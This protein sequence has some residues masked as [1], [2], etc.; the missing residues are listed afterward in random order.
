MAFMATLSFFSRPVVWAQ[1]NYGT[2]RGNVID[3]TGAV[4]P[5]VEVEATR[6]S[7]NVKYTA[8]ST[9]A[10]VYTIIDLPLGEYQ[11]RA[12]RTGFKEFV[13]EHVFVAVASTTT[14]NISLELGEVTQRVT[15]EG[16]V[17]PLLTPD[18][19]NVGTVVEK[20]L[21]MDLPLSVNGGFRDPESFLVLT[22]GIT[23]DGFSKN[24]N[25]STWMASQIVVEGLPVALPDVPGISHGSA[26]GIGPGTPPIE[27]YQEFKVSTTLMPAEQGRGFGLSS[28]T[29]KSGTNNFHGNAFDYLRNDALDARGFFNTVKPTVRQNDFG[30]TIGGPI[31][32]DKTF[33]FGAYSG[34]RIRGGAPTGTVTIPTLDFRKGDF[35]QLKD[36]QGNL[37]PIFDPQST[38][39]DGHGGFVRTAFPGNVIPTNRISAVAQRVMDLL[40]NPDFPGIVN[41][42]VDRSSA[43]TDN[44]RFSIKIDHIF[45]EK[46]KVYGNFWRLFRADENRL[47]QLGD[48]PLDSHYPGGAPITG[49]RVNWDWTIKPNLLNHLSYGYYGMNGL[50]RK[51]DPRRGNDLIK[52]PNTPPD[53][54]GMAGMYITGYP[55]FGNSDQQPEQRWSQGWTLA[56]NLSW[57]R[58]RH[59]LKFGGEHWIQRYPTIAL[60]NSGGLSGTFNFVNLET[61]QPNSPN[62]SAWGYPLASFLMGQV[63]SAS[64]LGGSEKRVLEQ[65]YL[66]FFVDDKIQ[67][68]PK[69]TLTLGLRYDIPW[70]YRD[71]KRFSGID[72]ALPN[73]GAGN[74]PGAYVFGAEK[75]APPIDWG[76]WGPRVGLAYTLN[77][78]TVVRAG[79]G[80]LYAQTNATSL[81]GYQFG[82]AFEAGYS[83]S[84]VSTQSLDSGVHPAFLLD[85]GFPSLPIPGDNLV[86]TVN[87]GGNADYLSPHGG[88]Q[89]Q[90]Q[91][92][93]LSI[94]RELPKGI[95]L[96]AA[97]VGNK[98]TYLPSG[99]ENLNQV[100]VSFLGLGPL[101]TQDIN[102]PAAIAAGIQ[103]PY[104]GFTGSVAQALRPFPQY[105]NIYNAA[106][107]IGDMTYN[108]L[109]MKVQ[110]RFS[111]G[112]SFLVSY[113]LSKT[114]T[115]TDQG[116]YSAFSSAGRD[117]AN[118]QLE[119]SL[120]PN[121]RPH[122]L[123]TSWVY[124]LPGAGLTGAKGALLKGWAVSGITRYLSGTPIGVAG[125]P[126]LPIFGGG[127]RPN[128]VAGVSA[129]SGVGAG[130]FDPAIDSYLNPAAFSQ[131]DP[132][133]IGNGA[134]LEPNLR[135]FSFWNENFSL[136]KRTYVSSIREGL[137]VEIR[138]DFFNLFNRVVFSNPSSD[139]NSPT[140]FGTVGGQANQPRIIQLGFKINF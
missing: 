9:D 125:G 21:V 17:E 30:G 57:I 120:A 94:Q 49:W 107:P 34:I 64:K 96:D 5:G 2:I 121:D 85:D 114:I 140:N 138:A 43:K 31:F 15:V 113:T 66:A 63:D 53:A 35:S 90:T 72:L 136:I 108:A 132:F 22:P 33:F 78:K 32:K 88:K 61:S 110:K 11:V 75:L 20:A 87:I 111:K 116:G 29:L 16:A 99:L 133:T 47:F 126:P 91:N 59:Q 25:G 106:Q 42:F 6:A 129:R 130:S 95:A 65:Y 80:I 60:E 118:R 84:G 52:I 28:Y 139:F 27:A 131:P 100:P 82:N 102:S 89:G 68:S 55:E 134:R 23:S 73:P 135:G 115:D 76:E 119:K 14:L 13:G 50:G 127:N 46:Q 39:P 122:N 104:P 4:V 123:V 109:Q 51:P 26:G 137:N 58:G 124:E 45:N 54:P 8:T 86:P 105:T 24:F 41:N 19:A 38:Q 112:L 44:D 117:N 81:G 67:V 18:S 56:E 36:S 97:Y 37:I 83:G 98:G 79:Y 74:R 69:L 10:G 71:N 1:T 12:R 128:R 70:A 77:D 103:A 3:S 40:P 92:W 7:T 93:V 48:N 101:L 62:Y